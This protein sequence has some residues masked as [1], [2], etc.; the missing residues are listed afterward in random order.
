MRVL[1]LGRDV[2]V[3][4]SW[5]DGQ[6]PSTKAAWNAC[7]QKQSL[8]P[9]LRREVELRTIVNCA[10][11]SKNRKKQTNSKIVTTCCFLCCASIVSFD[12]S[13]SLIVLWNALEFVDLSKSRQ[14]NQV[15]PRFK[16]T[17]HTPKRAVFNGCLLEQFRPSLLQKN[18][19]TYFPIQ[20]S[21]IVALDRPP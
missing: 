15:Y 3:Q 2:D 18:Q 10:L 13:F 12:A 4:Q 6:A 1:Y 7:P 20:V 11:E 16:F 9:R 17:L 8:E 19:R 5:R 14:K 21:K